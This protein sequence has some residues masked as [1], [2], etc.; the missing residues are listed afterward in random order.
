MHAVEKSVSPNSQMGGV[1]KSTF[2]VDEQTTYEGR[3]RRIDL[4]RCV[5]LG[6]FK[7]DSTSGIEKN[8]I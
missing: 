3:T 5:P 1:S 8:I 4:S 2:T 6:S 7:W